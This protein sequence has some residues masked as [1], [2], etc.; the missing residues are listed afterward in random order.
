MANNS[1]G[2]PIFYVS[3][4]QWLAAN[5]QLEANGGYGG[6]INGYDPNSPEAYSSKMELVNINPTSQITWTGN[7]S[8]QSYPIQYQSLVDFNKIMPEKN[9]F[10]MFL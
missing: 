2:R 5:G 4:L 7:S 10:Q 6:S 8:H 3:V 1:V 9:N